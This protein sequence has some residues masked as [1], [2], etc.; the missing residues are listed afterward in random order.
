MT[1]LSKILLAVSVTGFAAGGF[2]DFGGFSVMPQLT[3][4]LPLGAVFFGLFMIA[5]MMQK[6][7]AK[8]DEEESKKLQLNQRDTTAPVPAQKPAMQSSGVQFK[9]RALLHGH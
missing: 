8:F 3:V 6:E 1:T 9:E 7:M 5:F 2:V 4:A